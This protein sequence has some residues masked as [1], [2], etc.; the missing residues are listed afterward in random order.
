MSFILFSC[1]LCAFPNTH[2][3]F[4]LSTPFSMFWSWTFYLTFEESSKENLSAEC[5]VPHT[6]TP[7][8]KVL[9]QFSHSKAPLCS[10]PVEQLNQ[11][12]ILLCWDIG[13]EQRIVLKPAH[14]YF[15]ALGISCLIFTGFFSALLKHVQGGL[16]YSCWFDSWKK[17]YCFSSLHCRSA[18]NEL[19]GILSITWELSEIMVL[20]SS[21]NQYPEDNTLHKTTDFIL[22]LFKSL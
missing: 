15:P 11:K 14:M 1:T 4:F 22:P 20:K 10:H 16:V 17:I 13:I 12:K 2:V 3:V 8:K 6:Q 9:L 21:T 7:C 5:T 19:I 18:S